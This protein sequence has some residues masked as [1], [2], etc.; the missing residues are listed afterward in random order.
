MK[1]Q[2]KPFFKERIESLLQDKAD[3][4]KFWEIIDT[5]LPKTIRCNTLKI[6][7]EKLKSRLQKKWK[8]SQP[9]KSNPEI[10]IIDS[11][12][13]PGELGKSKE[14]LLGYYYIQELSSMMPILALN[15]DSEDIC[16]DLCAAPGSKTTQASA[17]MQNKGTI[18]ANDVS[19]GRISIL[20][21]NLERI[22]ASNTI[23]TRHDGVQLCKKL[24]KLKLQ[25]SKIL[26]DAPCSGEGNIR[27]NPATFKM[28]NL[29]VINK[30]S[31]IQKKI[32][33]SALSVLKPGGELLYSTCTH[34]PE[35]NELVIQN[36]L[37]K[38]GVKIQP[39]NLPLKTR[40]G[41]TSWQGQTLSPELKKAVRIYP[42]D[43]NTEGF[44]LCKIK[45]TGKRKVAIILFYGNKGNILL[46]DRK[47]M[48]KWG[49]EYGYFG[50]KIEED[51]N[52]RH[53]LKRELKEELGINIKNFKLFKDY[54]ERIELKKNFEMD[55]RRVVYI[56]KIPDIKKLKVHE[57]KIVL[58]NFKPAFNLKMIP[59]DIEL[60]KEIYEYLKD[61]FK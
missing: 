26:V 34:A 48:K 27:S 36:I 13:Q 45:K 12:L 22:G 53:A 61:K 29:K 60:L 20:S 52:P 28:W 38:Y 47:D 54:E 39:I 14:H 44:F 7:P 4:D 51:E 42:Q 31:R 32:A 17:L 30:L 16:L 37:D 21:A 49:E 55:L 3:I 35:E 11:T 8:I 41:L 58:T 46:Q 6:S 19:L 25:F 33:E 18:I 1:Y 50:G 10:M 24:G 57:G 59:G 2:P 56:A 23:I 5:P 9:Y 40:P 43:N 15:P